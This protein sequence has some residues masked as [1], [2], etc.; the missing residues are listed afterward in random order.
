[1]VQSRDLLVLWALFCA[2]CS[3]ITIAASS[4]TSSLANALFNGPGLTVLSG[5]SYS[6]NTQVS[7]IFD[8]GPYGIGN[9]AILITGQAVRAL[10][11]GSISVNDWG[12]GSPSYGGTSS[13]SD[14]AALAV[15]IDVDIGY[16]GELVEIILASENQA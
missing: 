11:G 6:G 12:S 5:A 2:P 13:T 16:D 15:N 1:M 10:P 9:G 7:G 8:N 14:V 4:N 3:G